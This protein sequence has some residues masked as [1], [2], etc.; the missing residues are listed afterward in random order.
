MFLYTAF[1]LSA[2][3]VLG[4]GT[5]SGFIGDVILQVLAV[6]LLAV[7]LAKC[8]KVRPFLV[9][10]PVG[11]ILAIA[12]LQLTPWPWPLQTNFITELA[13]QGLTLIGEHGS[14]TYVSIVP[15]ATA[16]A[17][18]SI[19]PALAIFYA[20]VLLDYDTRIKLVW[21]I[22]FWGGVS[23]L[24][25]FLQV[26]QG[27]GSSLRFFEI[28]NPTE[29][30][31]FF[32]NR[33]HFAAL[34]YVT[35][36]L[37]VVAY[38]DL[39]QRASAN[40]TGQRGRSKQSAQTLALVGLCLMIVA[41]VAGAAM[42]R[43]RAGIVLMMVAGVGAAFLA[44]RYGALGA[45]TSGSNSRLRSRAVTLAIAGAVLFAA[46]FGLYRFISRFEADP[47]DD[48]RW[49]YALATYHAAIETLPFATGF[50]SFIPVFAALEPMGITG[51]VF[52]NRAHNDALEMTLELGLGAPILLIAAL[53]T[54]P[55]L[56]WAARNTPEAR[57]HGTTLPTMA[58]LTLALI[59]L[60]SLFDY[61][62]R[63]SAIMA[64]VSNGIAL[65]VPRAETA[66][67]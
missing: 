53:A 33:N 41:T 64:V 14:W 27:P 32:A 56:Y 57:R 10:I 22:V 66:R 43:S 24:L 44:I 52:S 40:L 18:V 34:M 5:R 48:A 67:S 4:G 17:L 42:A 16:A 12:V 9:A 3:I 49:A 6:P 21:V 8:W 36:L 39:Q 37:S 7:A 19:L 51:V 59:G 55:F 26:A 11:C 61:P 47:F 65:M 58:F 2:S 15:N 54:L 46:Q 1:L 62:L 35:L 30:V 25:G 45:G 23:V 13:A 31:G 50:G 28:T 20:T 60:H 29:A 63:T 38:I